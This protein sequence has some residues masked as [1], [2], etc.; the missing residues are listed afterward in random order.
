MYR[1]AFTAFAGGLV[2]GFATHWAERYLDTFFKDVGG[3][4]SEFE[5][6]HDE[7]LTHYESFRVH[8]RHALRRSISSTVGIVAAH[9]FAGLILTI[10]QF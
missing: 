4:V 8:L 9:P 5:G 6:K 1:G 3:D 7:D 10:N 2:G